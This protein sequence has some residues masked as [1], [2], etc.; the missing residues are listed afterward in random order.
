MRSVLLGFAVACKAPTPSVPTAP[1]DTAAIE[2]GDT[3]GQEVSNWSGRIQN[4]GRHLGSEVA[5]VDLDPPFVYLAVESEGWYDSDGVADASA[6]LLRLDL[7]SGD[8]ERTYLATGANPNRLSLPVAAPG[9]LDGDGFVDVLFGLSPVLVLRGPF[10]SATPR[11]IELTDFH[12]DDAQACDVDRDGQADFCGRDGVDR[13]PVDGVADLRWPLIQPVLG[14]TTTHT[15]LRTAAGVDAVK[16]LG[17]AFIRADYAATGTIDLDALPAWPY[18]PGFV[19]HA[20]SAWDPDGDGVD[21][22]LVCATQDGVPGLRVIDDFAASPPVLTT[23]EYPCDALVVADFTGDGTPEVAIG[24]GSRVRIVDPDGWTL[25]A[26]W[27][28]EERPGADDL[29]KGLDARDVDGDGRADL[30]AGAPATGNL[31]VTTEAV[32]R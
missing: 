2:T 28:G 5:F 25:L 26:E 29:G 24:G 4:F 7:T 21:D 15:V 22:L 16:G 9:D 20:T 13:G 3:A 30:F 6:G 11:T 1:T 27:I 31:Y 17:E 10:D 8:V 14:S 19:L 32:P 12:G 18:P 23:L